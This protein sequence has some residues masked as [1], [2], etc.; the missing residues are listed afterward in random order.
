M[1]QHQC[2]SLGVPSSDL[3]ESATSG[4]SRGSLHISVYRAGAGDKVLRKVPY[5]TRPP[6]EQ[7]PDSYWICLA[8]PLHIIAWSLQEAG[9]EIEL[10][11]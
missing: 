3:S 5:Q 9:A 2:R 1:R 11:V 4:K 7:L 10:E 8:L 6:G